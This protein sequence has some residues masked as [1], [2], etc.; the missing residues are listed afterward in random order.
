M[1]RVLP[2]IEEVRRLRP[3]AVLSVD[4]S[5]AE[6]ARAAVQLGVEIVNDVTGL[7]G[8]RR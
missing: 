7:T 4:T 1:Q 3:E 2:V 6:V 8:M 5:K